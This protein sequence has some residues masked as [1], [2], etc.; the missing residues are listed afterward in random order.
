LEGLGHVQ[1][2]CTKSKEVRQNSSL[3]EMVKVF[4]DIFND[5]L[6]VFTTPN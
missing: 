4:E 5:I 3:L 2:E 6:K 1:T